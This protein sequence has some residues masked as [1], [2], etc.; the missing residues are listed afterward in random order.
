MEAPLAELTLTAAPSF[1]LILLR[2]SVW[3]RQQ[4]EVRTE[5]IQAA[6]LRCSGGGGGQLPIK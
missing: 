5:P 4:E 3:T 2:G 6:A 1:A